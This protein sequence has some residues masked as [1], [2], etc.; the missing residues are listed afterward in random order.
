MHKLIEH[1]EGIEYGAKLLEKGTQWR[2]GMGDRIKFW[3][4]LW[5]PDMGRL[6]DHAIVEIS[7]DELHQ[8]VGIFLDNDYWQVEQLRTVLP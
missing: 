7:A 8:T 4:D 1:L 6:K 3:L 2:V 5:V